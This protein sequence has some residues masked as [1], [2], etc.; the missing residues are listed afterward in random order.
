MGQ[1]AKAVVGRKFL[2]PEISSL[3][4]ADRDDPHRGLPGI[5]ASPIHSF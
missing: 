2:V 3:D 4:D 5:G 1:A